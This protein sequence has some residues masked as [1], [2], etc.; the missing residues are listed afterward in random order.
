MQ[1]MDDDFISRLQTLA[2]RGEAQNVKYDGVVARLAADEFCKLA[3]PGS[4]ETMRFASIMR[5]AL[6]E[7][8]GLSAQ[9]IAESIASNPNVPEAVLNQIIERG[10]E[11]ATV[12]LEAAPHISTALLL[13][14]AEC[15]ATSEAAA[16]ARRRDLDAPVIAALARRTE[17]E[18]L[19]ALAANPTAHISRG[20]LL[21]LVQRGRFDPPL[22]RAL[23]AR[24]DA[25]ADVLCLFL[26]ADQDR[27]RTIMTDVQRLE[28]SRPVRAPSPLEASRRTV[29]SAAGA[30]NLRAFANAIALAMRTSRADVERMIE[31]EGGEP[32]ALLFSATGA[33]TAAATEAIA[34]LAPARAVHWRDNVMLALGMN[35]GAAW[36]IVNA[37]AHGRTRAPAAAREFR[38]HAGPPVF[39]GS[40]HREAPLVRKDDL[41]RA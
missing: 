17:P 26:A 30:G 33:P 6:P 10:R 14:R 23:L 13:A 18:T 3:Q 15:G 38:T 12:I 37:V 32:L 28:L 4:A 31:D 39:D 11:A 2:E 19:R 29:L 35:A 9:R 21:N 24:V 34:A 7:T 27:R 41:S 16:I 40:A 20:A 36:R 25:G 1:Q 22:A 8:D 5:E